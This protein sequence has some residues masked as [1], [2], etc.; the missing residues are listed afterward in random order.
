MIIMQLPKTI[1]VTG[2]NRGLGLEITKQYLQLG[3]RVLA[4]CRKSSNVVDLNHLQRTNRDLHI[5]HVDLV[6]E[7]EIFALPQQIQAESIDIL[8]NN[9]GVLGSSEINS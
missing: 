3:W 5:Y 4:C 8:F 6:Y 1:L 2:A 9:A 7:N